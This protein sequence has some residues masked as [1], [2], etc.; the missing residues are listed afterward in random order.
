MREDICILGAGVTGLA[1]G[2]ISKYPIYEATH[3][4]GG[5]CSSYYIHS[6]THQRCQ[7]PDNTDE[8][9]RFESGGGHWIFGGD[10][11]VLG[12][13][14]SLVDVK[15][16]HRRSSVFFSAGRKIVP[17]PLQNHLFHFDKEIS[18]KVISEILEPS[19]KSV[20][21]MSDWFRNHF[22]NTLSDIFFEPFHARYMGGLW[23]KV[24]PQDLDKSPLDISLIIQGASHTTPSVGY[25]TKF[26][27]PNGGLDCLVKKLASRCDVKFGSKVLEINMHKREILFAN[28]KVVHY[29]KILSTIPLNYM[30]KIVGCNVG[31]RAD[32]WISVLT[33][34]VAAVRGPSCPDDYWVYTPDSKSGFYRI[35][36]YSNVDV[37]FLPRSVQGGEEKVS[38]YVERAYK[39]GEKPAAEEIERYSQELIRE[40]QEWEFIKQVEIVDPT[41]IEVAYTWTW[42]QSPWRSNLIEHLEKHKIYQIGRYGRWQFQGI[43]ASLGEG[44]LAGTVLG[45]A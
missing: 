20:E 44:L 14:R 3:S 27:Y 12:F 34:N 5:I 19:L 16:Y 7:V 30:M 1:A 4:L 29:D 26:L 41:W 2:W 18:D 45:R 21:T 13:I 39:G 25:N 23:T 28:K 33:L 6:E 36:F 9:Y 17:Y 8:F 15:T 32:P 42:P 31:E 40:L 22:G 35:G 43:A 24:S 10:P 37:S 11:I 38:L